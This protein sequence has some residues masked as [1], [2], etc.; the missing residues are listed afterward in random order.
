[1]ASVCVQAVLLQQAAQRLFNVSLTYGAA[2]PASGQRIE[3]QLLANGAPY[4][5]LTLYELGLEPGQSTKTAWMG[6]GYDDYGDVVDAEF[7]LTVSSWLVGAAD[8]TTPPQTVNSTSVVFLDDYTFDPDAY[9]ATYFPDMMAYCEVRAGRLRRRF[10]A[11]SATPLLVPSVTCMPQQVSLEGIVTFRTGSFGPILDNGNGADPLIDHVLVDGINNA[12]SFSVDF[13]D[14][15]MYSVSGAGCDWLSNSPHCNAAVV[16]SL[17]TVSSQMTAYST[18]TPTLVLDF[19]SL[20]SWYLSYFTGGL[21]YLATAYDG[22]GN[23]VATAICAATNG[24]ANAAP[25]VAVPLPTLYFYA[26][27]PF[28][29]S[30]PSDWWQ[31]DYTST[32]LLELGYLG[33]CSYEGV[34]PSAESLPWSRW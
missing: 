1:M 33:A 24:S 15:D 5:L 27:V 16:P 29:Y 8:L 28:N 3:L 2:C 19:A 14:I 21:Q 12:S 18:Y 6:V 34:R 10:A 22:G 9:Y 17:T 4:S 30:F 13:Y 11:I 23:V 26:D 32:P 25:A 20:P 7:S 31:D